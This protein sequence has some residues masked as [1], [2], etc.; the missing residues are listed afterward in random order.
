MYMIY[1]YINTC[2]QEW[3]H[4]ERFQNG[5][6][7]SVPAE[8]QLQQAGLP[9]RTSIPGWDPILPIQHFGDLP[10]GELT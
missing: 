7:Q 10:S 4:L 8:G 1:I 6:F 3:F 5:T 9:G 2:C